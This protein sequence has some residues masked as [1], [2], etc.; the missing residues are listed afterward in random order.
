MSS[1]SGSDLDADPSEVDKKA[2]ALRQIEEYAKRAQKLRKEADEAEQ[3]RDAELRKLDEAA[4]KAFN[5][6]LSDAEDSER[7]KNREQHNRIVDR[8]MDDVES[9][10]YHN[11]E[12]VFFTSSAYSGAQ[13]EAVV[14]PLAGQPVTAARIRQC[15][16]RCLFESRALNVTEARRLQF[17]VDKLD[18]GVI[19]DRIDDFLHLAVA[20]GH[21]AADRVPVLRTLW[22]KA[23]TFPPAG[24]T[25][26]MHNVDAFYSEL[27]V[28]EGATTAVVV[29]S[30]CVAAKKYA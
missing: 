14:G 9:L 29:C 30:I 3:L 22:R 7:K 21:I 5:K 2:A 8:I 24:G 13:S 19:G 16:M 6:Q 20:A 27:A 1:G 18:E 11:S 23:P 4:V 10:R 26:R 15:I 28:P 12:A 17:K 25:R